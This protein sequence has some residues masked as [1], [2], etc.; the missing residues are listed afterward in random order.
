MNESAPLA[1]LA[2]PDG[3]VVLGHGP[4]TAAAVPPADGVAFYVQRYGLDEPEPWRIPAAV[5]HLDS[6]ALEARFS[7]RPLPV[8][9]WAEIDAGPFAGVFQ[10]VMDEIRRGTFEKTVP[11][12]VEEGR[13]VSGSP[14]DVA[15]AMTRQAAPRLSYAWSEG[16]RGF[17]GA[18]P[19]VLFS[20]SGRKLT[21]MALAG[22]AKREERVVFAVD[23]KEIRE[24]EYV[25]QSLVAK[26]GDIGTVHRGERTILDLG[27]L[28]HFLSPIEVELDEPQ[29]PSDLIRRLHPTPAL[30]PHP[31]TPGTLSQL[32]GWRRR[33][34]CPYEF[35]APFGVWDCGRFDAIVAIRGVWW[36]GNRVKLPAGCGVIEVSRLVNEWRELRLKREAVK[37]VLAP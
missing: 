14:F 8:C 34:G 7:D 1:W 10:E 25:A 3:S 20:L 16:D 12:V 2:R 23:E 28:V 31:R 35:G 29:K 30:G 26:L 15:A 22:T 24:H 36:D 18:T 17:S 11:V 13:L 4:F 19:E 5:E 37:H 32:I 6:A 33:L 27:S 9:E 21:T